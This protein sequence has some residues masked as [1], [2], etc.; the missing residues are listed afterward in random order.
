M[1]IKELKELLLSKQSY[2]KKG[3]AWLS[4]KYGIPE[5][6]IKKLFE[7]LKSE[8]KE[9][10]SQIYTGTKKKLQITSYLEK[11]KDKNPGINIDKKIDNNTRKIIPNKK[12]DPNNVLIIGDLH[13]PWCLDNYL[14]FNLDLQKKYNVGKIIF[15]GDIVDGH[16]WN[17]HTHDVDGMSV[18]DELTLAISKLKNWYKAFPEASITLGNHD[19][20]ISRKAREYGLSQLFVKHLGD[21]LE[22]PKSW[23]FVQELYK[24]KVFYTHGSTGNAIT[25]AR[26][27][28]HSVVQG[29]LHSESF[30]QWSVSQIDAIFGLQV[31]CGIDRHAYAFEYAKEMPKKPIISSGLVLEK[32]RL[33]ILELM[34]L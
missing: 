29:H 16:A 23:E 27:I 7:E 14:D 15:I 17:F 13:E 12:G 5:Y 8:K 11:I 20:L 4:F 22:A 30:V 2:F 28:R 21:I 26:D 25:R 9:Y 34:K 24:D 33:P 32:G 6:D 18:K 31:G 1:T 3:V 10:R 19:L